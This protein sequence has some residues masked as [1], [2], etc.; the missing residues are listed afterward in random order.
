MTSG[1]MMSTLMTLR[2]QLEQRQQRS[3]GGSRAL[4]R[5]IT[6]QR[7]LWSKIKPLKG[8]QTQKPAVTATSA[9]EHIP[10]VLCAVGLFTLDQGWAILW[11]KIRYFFLAGWYILLAPGMLLC[12]A[13]LGYHSP[14][15]TWKSF[16]RFASFFLYIYISFFGYQFNFIPTIDIC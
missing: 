4:R 15:P 14:L 7:A 12:C 13:L 6:P 1:L 16:F 10:Q 2:W 9:D 3:W 8:E 5:R 11:I